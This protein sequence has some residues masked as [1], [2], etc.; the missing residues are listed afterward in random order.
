M[1]DHDPLD[2][3]EQEKRD[4]IRRAS[5]L[6]AIENDVAGFVWLMS[7]PKG[8]RFVRRLLDQTGVTLSSFCPNAMEMSKREGRK[9]IGYWIRDLIE[10]HCP[11][12]Y[13]TMMQEKKNV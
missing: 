4:D 2:L 1:S 3:D 6:L 10:E 5:S 13:H 7:G 11:Q 12:D 8:R 9:Q